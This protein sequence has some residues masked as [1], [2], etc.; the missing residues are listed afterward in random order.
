MNT[1]WFLFFF[2]VFVVLAKWICFPVVY[3][4]QWPPTPAMGISLFVSL[5]NHFCSRLQLCVPT[6]SKQY[7]ITQEQ[8]SVPKTIP[9]KAQVLLP[10]LS[11]CWSGFP[12]PLS[13]IWIICP[14]APQ[15]SRKHVPELLGDTPRVRAEEGDVELSC[16]PCLLQLSGT[17]KYSAVWKLK[18]ALLGFYE[19][20]ITKAQ[21]LIDWAWL[22]QSLCAYHR[23]IRLSRLWDML[24]L[25][26]CW[27]S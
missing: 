5:W 10:G 25:K 20:L 3:L 4:S 23:S 8:G 12:Q 18:S 22:G 21:L 27:G 9:A 1:Y 15:N 26:W 17:W 6:V 24:L 11:T 13:W 16:L 14:S 7:T 19:D 2:Y